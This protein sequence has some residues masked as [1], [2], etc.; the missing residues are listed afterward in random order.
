MRS[1]HSS[2]QQHLQYEKMRYLP[3][4]SIS[5]YHVKLFP[6]RSPVRSPGQKSWRDVEETYEHADRSSWPPVEKLTDRNV[7]ATRS[8]W[9]I[10]KSGPD[11]SVWLRFHGYSTGYGRCCEDAPPPPKKN[12]PLA[13]H[14]GTSSWRTIMIA[15]GPTSTTKIPGKMKSTSGKIIFTAVMAAFSSAS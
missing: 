3:R 4:K 10:E 7:C 6:A 15:A 14:Y 1:S 2:H 13:E 11:I 9:I 12:D 5:F 8:I